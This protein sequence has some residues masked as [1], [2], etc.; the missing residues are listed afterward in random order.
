MGANARQYI[1][2]GRYDCERNSWIPGGDIRHFISSHNSGPAAWRAAERAEGDLGGCDGSDSLTAVLRKFARLG[3]RRAAAFHAALE[4][5][6]S[7]S[8]DYYEHAGWLYVGC[9]FWAAHK[10]VPMDGG[11]GIAVRD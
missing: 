2:I 1:V 11:I 4:G 7:Q 6:E 8:A 10:I 3:T 5:D 9:D